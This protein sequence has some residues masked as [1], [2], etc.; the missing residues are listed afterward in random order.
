MDGV[1]IFLF[2]YDGPDRDPYPCPASEPAT[3][4][5]IP[6]NNRWRLLC[7][8]SIS[9][10]RSRISISFCRLSSSHHQQSPRRTIVAWDPRCMYYS[11]KPISP[12]RRTSVACSLRVCAISTNL[13]FKSSTSRRSSTRSFL[14]SDVI[15]VMKKEVDRDSSPFSFL[16]GTE[17]ERS[18]APYLLFACFHWTNTVCDVNRGS[19]RLGLIPQ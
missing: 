16:P 8:R 4:P 19:F 17:E 5:G 15:Q 10:R 11:L 14:I 9:I 18:D 3:C 12:G 7:S 13:C 6:Y 1:L 2:S